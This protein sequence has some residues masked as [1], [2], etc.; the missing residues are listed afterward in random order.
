[1]FDKHLKWLSKQ[2]KKDLVAL[3]SSNNKNF[4]ISR[5]ETGHSN[6]FLKVKKSYYYYYVTAPLKENKELSSFTSES[7]PCV[8]KNF[9]GFFSF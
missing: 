3:A 8:N 9:G 1:M 4:I 6:A 7:Y 2:S 5:S